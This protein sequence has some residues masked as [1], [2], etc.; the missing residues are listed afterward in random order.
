MV[1]DPSGFLL[2]TDF[3]QGLVLRLAPDGTVARFADVR[4][5]IGI[6]GLARNPET[7]EVVVTLVS[8][9]VKRISADGSKVD[10]LVTHPVLSSPTAVI[11]E[12][13][14]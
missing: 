1:A 14:K 2:L 10:T 11:V 4:V 13:N 8:N 12:S 5:V 7:G 3:R 6:N 9:G